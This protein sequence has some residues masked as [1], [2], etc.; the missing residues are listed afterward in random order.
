MKINKFNLIIVLIFMLSSIGYTQEV[1]LP[2]INAVAIDHSA[3]AEITWE[4]PVNGVLTIF[5]YDSGIASGQLGFTGEAPRGVVG[6]CHRENA[7]LDKIQWYLTDHPQINTTHVNIYI[8]DLDEVGMPTKNILHSALNIPTTVLQW[9][10][11]QFPMTVS[12]PNGFYMALSRSSG[13]NLAL[14]TS[15]PTDEYPFLPNTH[16]FSPDFETSNFTV[17]TQSNFNI[18][19][20]LRA[21]GYVLGKAA[22]FGY[23]F[24]TANK[25]TEISYRI[26]RLL[27]GQQNNE[28]QWTLLADNVTELSFID[29][30]WNTVGEGIYR[31][32]VKAKY[33]DEILSTPRFTNILTKG[34]E[35]LYTVNLTSN[36]G[37]PVNGAVIKLTNQDGD[38]EHV[39]TQTATDEIVI[40]QKVWKG[41]YN[42][43]VTL[44]GFHP[45]IATN[46]IVNAQNLTHNVE[47]IEII[48]PVVNPVAK[49]VGNNVVINWE[50]PVFNE[51]LKHCVD[52]DVEYKFGWSESAG[53]NMTAAMR[54][55]SNDLKELGIISGNTITKVALGIGTHMQ[56]VN[57][58]ELRIWEGG[59]SLTS[60]GTLT[61][62]QPITDFLYFYEMEMNEIELTVPYIIDA[63]KELRIGYRLLNTAG[64]PF[65]MDKGPNVS[66]KG[67]LFSCPS[68][69]GGQWLCI[70]A[71]FGYNYNWS[72]KAFVTNNEK[73]DVSTLTFENQSNLF[74]QE[75]GISKELLSY[76]VYRL[77]EGQPEGQWDLIAENVQGLTYTDT[78]WSSLSGNMYQWA[79]KAVY[80]SVPSVA[81]LTN[82]LP[83]DMEVE[84]TVNI[85]TNSGDPVNGAKITLTN[86]NGN[87][88]YIY[89]Q[90]ADGSSTKFPI[91]WRGSYEIS[92]VLKD[93]FPYTSTVVINDNGLSYNAVLEEIL[94]PVLK[95]EAVE[96]N[97]NVTISWLKPDYFEEWIKYCPYD[98]IVG[99][100]GWDEYA[101]N[102]MTAAIRFLPSDLQA[103]GIVT[104]HVISKLE[105]GIGT[106]I[107]RVNFM[108]ISIW[109]GGT[110]VTNP[111]Q[112]LYTQEI[113]NYSSFTENK[114]NSVDLTTPFIIDATKELR[115]GYRIINEAGYPF[116]RDAGPNVLGKSLLFFCTS[117][118][119]WLDARVNY[120]WNWNWSLKAWVSSESKSNNSKRINNYSVYR[121]LENSPENEWILLANDVTELNYTDNEWKTLPADSYQWAVYANYTTGQ[122][123]AKITNALEKV[124]SIE[125]L[126]ITNYELRIYPN[127]TTGVFYVTVVAEYFPPAQSVEIFDVFGRKQNFDYAQLPKAESRK[128]NGDGSLVVDI[129]HLINGVYFVVIEDINGEKK[130]HKIFKK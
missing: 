6:S 73:S 99:R 54:F 83:K 116:G 112:L 59:T 64:F 98:E 4:E 127:P 90:I 27:E 109:Q 82:S 67:G 47:L 129:S 46:V 44:K 74:E 58:M 96:I 66:Q 71:F 123:I 9:C 68:I 65:G 130:V 41:T 48:Y 117:L 45:Y 76:S 10:E 29:H 22:Q 104:G 128:Q 51:W 86:N 95:P 31:W 33:A 3:Y 38:P 92:I 24:S 61:Y 7:V 42:I 56:N 91:V 113:E 43:S 85:T 35:F 19:F 79:I 97:N 28:T 118:G 100:V 80:S 23:P 77:V 20:M 55:T 49:I 60:P 120:D 2:P 93:F 12:A 50:E 94:T 21:E 84:Y 105:L 5:R 11:Y 126:R 101:G 39:Y 119:G 72:L 13:S 125:P 102:D 32:A 81:K 16:F 14:G 124:V 78:D 70:N 111:G 37:D 57:T 17:V 103:L 69:N 115:I 30:G 87:A 34:K 122:S 88:Q 62:V 114:M 18:N 108:E 1:A 107:N 106:E 110:S 36:S 25:T 52:D 26:Y 40:F 8:F 53:N 15:T 75:R 121:L 89:N 63:T